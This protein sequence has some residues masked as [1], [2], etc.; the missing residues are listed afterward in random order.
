MITSHTTRAS[1]RHQNNVGDKPDLMAI[2]HEAAG[3]LALNIIRPGDAL[4]LVVASL[5]GGR[6][7]T[8][9]LRAVCDI[10]ARVESA[11]RKKPMLCGC[12]PRPL[13]GS[14]FVIC[15]AVPDRD[16]PTN[17]LAFAL[18]EHCSRDDTA[19]LGKASSALRTIWPDLRP[20]T[21]TN[22]VGGHA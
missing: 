20:I 4:N 7:A 12:C 1:T 22:P 19:L 3:V 11:P 15:V 21:I 17:G 9:L 18:C 2:H 10:V 14:G 5:E 6:E 16:S 13:R 8:R